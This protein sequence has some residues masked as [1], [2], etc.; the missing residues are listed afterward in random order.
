MCNRRKEELWR[1]KKMERLGCWATNREKI[2]RS[3]QDMTGM[4]ISLRDEI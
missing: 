4:T 2:S 3:V 1:K